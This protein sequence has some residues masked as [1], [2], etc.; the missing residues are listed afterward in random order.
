[1][2]EYTRPNPER[3][4]L[5]TI[6]TQRDFSLPGAPAEIPGTA[7]VVPDI[8]RLLERLRALERPIVHVVRLYRPDG[9]NVDACRR[10][11]IED[12]AAIA[13]PGSTGSELVDELRPEGASDLDADALLAG[14]LDE[15]GPLEWALYKPRWGAFYETPLESHLDALGVDTL[16]VCG[17][18]FPNCPR[19]TVYEASKRDYRVVFVAD[20]T[21]GTYERGLEELEGIGVS[22]METDEALEWLTPG[23]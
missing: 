16:V 18:N 12:G 11:A 6:D 9:S 7:A 21:S 20:A 15:L 13:R 22:V 17:C 5:L 4:A 2:N 14:D 1:M 23:A 8:A 19:T 3:A 10:A